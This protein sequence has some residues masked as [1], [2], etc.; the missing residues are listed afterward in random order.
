V[1]FAFVLS[2]CS[3]GDDGDDGAGGPAGFPDVRGTYSGRLTST[4]SGCTNP[5]D[6]GRQ[7]GDVTFITISRQNG[8][9]FQGSGEFNFVIDGQVT[10]DGD[11][12]FTSIGGT[13]GFHTEL[14]FRGT[15]VGDTLTAEWSG[16]QTAGDTCVFEDGQ[17]TATRQ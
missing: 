14:A 10:L 15:L 17:F 16:R 1:C 6:N 13:G 8:A 11:L 7:T 2:G 5:A 4:N 9:A 3:G 12:S